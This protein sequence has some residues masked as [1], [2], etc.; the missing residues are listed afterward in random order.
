MNFLNLNLV[1]EKKEDVQKIIQK[2]L[3]K[4]KES[5]LENDEINYNQ[6]ITDK[7]KETGI[8]QKPENKEENILSNNKMK[9]NKEN[10]SKEKIIF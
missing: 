1:L 5:Q 8:I 2:E 7:I 3:T 4:N 10:L 6:K 9:V